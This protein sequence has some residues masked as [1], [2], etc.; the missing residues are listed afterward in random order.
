VR[1]EWFCVGGFQPRCSVHSSN[2]PVRGHSVERRL[3]RDPARGGNLAIE[4]FTAGPCDVRGEHI[5]GGCD[6]GLGVAS[7]R[8]EVTRLHQAHARPAQPYCRCRIDVG[9]LGIRP[10][11][12][13]DT[14]VQHIGDTDI[15]DER[16]ALAEHLRRQIDARQVGTNDLVLC[17]AL[18]GHISGRG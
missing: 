13:D 4:W 1:D 6:R 15:V 12:A 18:H 10:W 2:L 11:L 16:R 8:Y 7:Y 14:R 9:K 3:G 5:R 17:R